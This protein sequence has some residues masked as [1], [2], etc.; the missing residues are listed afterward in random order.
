[1][2]DLF[3]ELQYVFILELIMIFLIF[4]YGIFSVLVVRQINV[5]VNDVKTNMSTLIYLLGVLNVIFA[6]LAFIASLAL[7]L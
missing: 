6:V 5:L 7:V 3:S 4:G 1:M 2:I